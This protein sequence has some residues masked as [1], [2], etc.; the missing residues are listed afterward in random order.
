[1]TGTPL[2]D[3]LDAL[4]RRLLDDFQS[5]IPLAPRPFA[6]MAEQ[7]GVAEAEVIARLQRLTE[8]GA[9]SRV[10]PVFRPRQVG[11]STLAAMAVPPER[12]AEVATLVNGFP[13]VNHNY[14]REHDFNLWFVLTAPD[15]TRLEQVLDEIG[16][17]AGLPVMDL[18]M[19]AEYHI[20]LGFPLQWT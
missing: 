2:L 5:G 7:L 14:E 12:L 19:L 10:G 18:P 6:L 20:D 16:R 15:Q 4:D 17:R 13:E 9:I 11:A 3:R 8:A 1:M